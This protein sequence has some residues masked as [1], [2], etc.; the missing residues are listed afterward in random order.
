MWEYGRW[1]VAVTI[2]KLWK[3]ING[4]MKKIRSVVCFTIFRL[5]FK[6]ENR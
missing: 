6:A 1:E 2:A 4:N 5:N 3:V